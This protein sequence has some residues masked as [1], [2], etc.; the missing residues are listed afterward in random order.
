MA[1]VVT[2][3]AIPGADTALG[4]TWAAA[5]IAKSEDGI[6]GDGFLIRGLA[7]FIL[8][9]LIDG[10]GSGPEAARAANVGLQRIQ[11]V[12]ASDL[13]DI[14]QS[15]HRALQG[16]RG[17][18]LGLCRIDP[19]NAEVVWTSVGDVDGVL[20]GLDPDV[21]NQGIFQNNGTLGRSMSDTVHRASGRLS[22]G[23]TI[24]LTTDGVSK[25]YRKDRDLGPDPE[26]IVRRLMDRYGDPADDC[27]VICVQM[28]GGK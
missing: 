10:T 5:Q 15:T 12:E 20:R 26:T 14:C 23:D 27:S 11:K 1:V 9:A 22:P 24:L 19:I 25:A 17:A 28:E 13:G 7:D 3:G 6:A 2:G 8:I 16:T 18:A 4:M 21:P